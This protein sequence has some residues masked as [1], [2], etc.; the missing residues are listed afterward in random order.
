MVASVEKQAPPP[1][2]HIIV[3][4]LSTD[5]T[6][7]TIKSYA[8]R[9]PY[10]VIHRREAD[11]GIYDAMNRGAEI[12]SGDALY[13]LND[14]DALI[15]PHSLKTLALGLDRCRAD[16]AFA[17]VTV[18]DP[19]TG[20]SNL[21]SHRQVN[22]F[23]L[24]EKSICQQATLY[25]RR[26]LESVGPFDSSLRAAADY[27]WMLRAFL[28]HSARAAYL[29]FPVAQFALGGVSSSESNR[30]AFEKEMQSVRL[31][32][33]DPAGLAR[34][35]RFRRLWRKIPWGLAVMPD[36]GPSPRFAVVTRIPVAGRL[37]PNPL[38]WL[39]F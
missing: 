29:Q 15:G 17:D 10:P 9:V 26:I 39:G 35:K 6:E 8:S 20:T 33:Y 19:S 14:D 37:F 34:A 24:A 23:T 16:F 13:F 38:A 27:D 21:R 28:Q 25:S 30:S 22:R 1:A 18:V 12:A 3:D 36:L 32:Y 7:A 2:E 5:S 4:N 11:R 31:R